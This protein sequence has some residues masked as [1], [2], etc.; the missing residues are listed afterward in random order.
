MGLLAVGAR[1]RLVRLREAYISN[2]SILLSIEP[3]KKSVLGYFQILS[4]FGNFNYWFLGLKPQPNIHSS[5]TEIFLYEEKKSVCLWF[6]RGV[7]DKN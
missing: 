2:L 4:Q 6:F 3:F 5:F 1:G 7:S